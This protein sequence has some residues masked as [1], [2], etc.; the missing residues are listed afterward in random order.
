MYQEFIAGKVWQQKL[1]KYLDASNYSE[2]K[3]FPASLKSLEAFV[4]ESLKIHVR[5]L[6][7]VNNQRKPSYAEDV[8]AKI[9]E[10]DK[11]T[12]QLSTPSASRRNYANELDLNQTSTEISSD[13]S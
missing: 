9:K 12:F 10:L 3:K 2:F 5:Y 6:I 8:L 1:S 7:A 11:L 13:D 4:A